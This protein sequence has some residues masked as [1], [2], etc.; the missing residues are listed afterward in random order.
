[1]V[2]CNRLQVEEEGQPTFRRLNLKY[3]RTQTTNYKKRIKRL[4]SIQVASF[5]NVVFVLK[6]QDEGLQAFSY[7]TLR[8]LLLFSLTYSESHLQRNIAHN[9]I[10]VFINSI[11]VVKSYKALNEFIY[12]IK[13]VINQDQY[14]DH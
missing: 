14:Q 10:T 1:M 12:Q 5:F 13:E 8:L 3:F 6:Q 4:E 9:F 7:Y 11:H 2:N